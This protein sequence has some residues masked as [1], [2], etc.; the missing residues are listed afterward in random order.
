MDMAVGMLIERGTSVRAARRAV[1]V[2]LRVGLYES[3][4]T[5]NQRVLRKIRSRNLDQYTVVPSGKSEKTDL[6][7]VSEMWAAAELT[8]SV[9]S[10]SEFTGLSRALMIQHGIP[11]PASLTDIGLDTSAA[12]FVNHVTGERIL[13][14]SLERWCGALR[15]EPPAA[16]G[17]DRWDYR[18]TYRVERVSPDGQRTP[19]DLTTLGLPAGVERFGGGWSP[20]A[21][22]DHDAF[23]RICDA[24]RVTYNIIPDAFT[25]QWIRPNWRRRPRRTPFGPPDTRNSEAAT[26]S[27]LQLQ[28]DP[29]PPDW[30]PTT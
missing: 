8:A 28:E 26:V 11:I 5:T 2:P 16:D 3:L 10:H 15:P 21:H 25:A 12:E 1:G 19:I 30:L 24:I 7:A 14:Y 22:A 4:R 13:V 20:P 29:P 6:D 23:E 9:W 27:R 18:G 17:M